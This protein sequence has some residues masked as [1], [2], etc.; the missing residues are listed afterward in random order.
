MGGFVIGFLESLD[1]CAKLFRIR[2]AGAPQGL[3]RQNP[4]PNL[5]HIQPTRAG[6]RVM[7]ENIR[8]TRKPLIMMFV[9]TVI[10][11]DHM[12]FHALRLG[13]TGQN[14]FQK[15]QKT[16]LGFLR[17]ISRF[18][19]NL[20][21]RHFQGREQVQG[22]VTRVAAFIPLHQMLVRELTA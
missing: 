5:N 3:Q 19:V 1:V 18:A 8:M 22:A 17:R 15:R 16:S 21:G 10:V 2:E 4:K 7:K 12:I 20:P 13:Q 11:H 6:G 14:L 9:N